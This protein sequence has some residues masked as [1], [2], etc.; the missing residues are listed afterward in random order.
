MIGF[1]R[2]NLLYVA[3]TVALLSMLGSLYFSEVL[4]YPPCVLCWYQRIFMYPLV[5]IIAVAII[6]KTSDLRW[7]ILP[8]SIAGALIAV[9]HNLLYYKLLPE[10]IKPCVQG[11]SCTTKFIEWYGFVTIPFLSFVAF[12]AISLSVFF[13][14]NSKKT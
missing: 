2:K 3:W 7:Y 10:S 5:P 6:K 14:I 8:L 11:I 13:Y 9:Y 4:K 12:L 1:V